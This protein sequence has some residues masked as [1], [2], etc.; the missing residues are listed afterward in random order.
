MINYEIDC[1]FFILNCFAPSRFYSWHE[2]ICWT[3]IPAAVGQHVTVDKQDVFAVSSLLKFNEY[4]IQERWSNDW[5]N[6]NW[7]QFT[8]SNINA[9]ILKWK[10]LECWAFNTLTHS[11]LFSVCP[12]WELG[13]EREKQNTVK[14]TERPWHH[15]SESSFVVFDI[16]Q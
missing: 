3:E 11:R 1:F 2:H 12:E 4:K 16:S 10:W 8:W 15:F 9:N 14:E 6:G 7:L 13:S 5:G